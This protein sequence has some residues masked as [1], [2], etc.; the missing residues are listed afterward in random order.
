M[1][2]RFTYG[3]LQRQCEFRGEL[4][5]HCHK[6]C[7]FLEMA[8]TQI[9]LA[10]NKQLVGQNENLGQSCKCWEAED[11]ESECPVRLCIIYAKCNM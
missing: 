5:R 10:Q 11:D 8:K 3:K 1:E 9:E 4:I 2:S 6:V 7:T